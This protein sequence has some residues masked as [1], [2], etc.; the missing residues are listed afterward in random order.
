MLHYGI[1][2][3]KTIKERMVKGGHRVRT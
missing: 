2:S 3:I 1:E